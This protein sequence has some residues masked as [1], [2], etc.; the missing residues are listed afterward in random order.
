MWNTGGR[1]K[2]TDHAVYNNTVVDTIEVHDLVI[3]D[4]MVTDK[5]LKRKKILAGTVIGVKTYE[6][7]LL[8]TLR[9][10]RLDI[11]GILLL[12][13]DAQSN[14]D[15][16]RKNCLTLRCLLIADTQIIG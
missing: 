1:D 6:R 14:F 15:L 9:L 8:I 13:G 2:G 3:L 5:L 4:D 16:T 7:K 12:P 11:A 10:E